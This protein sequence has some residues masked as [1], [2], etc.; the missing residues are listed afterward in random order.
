[1]DIKRKAPHY[2][3]DYTDAISLQ[4]LASF[5][6]LYCAC[7]SPVITFGGLLGEATEGRVVRWIFIASWYIQAISIQEVDARLYETELDV[8]QVSNFKTI[9]YLSQKTTCSTPITGLNTF[10]LLYNAQK[11]LKTTESFR[12]PKSFLGE[13]KVVGNQP[14]RIWRKRGTESKILEVFTESTMICGA[15]SSAAIGPLGFLKSTVKAFLYHLEP[16]VLLFAGKFYVSADVIDLVPAS[17]SSFID[18][19]TVFD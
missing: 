15:M 1:M 5:L 9:I 8:D 3:S 19:V 12:G 17:Q 11:S 4:C 2:L 10:V 18:G 14:T 16:F 7:M 13:A 6:F